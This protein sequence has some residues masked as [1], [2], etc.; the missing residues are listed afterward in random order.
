ML[1]FRKINQMTKGAPKSDVMAFIGRVDSDPGNCAIKSKARS[2]I[3][4]SKMTMGVKNKWLE[5][6]NS[7]LPICGTAKPMKAIGPQNAVM[8]P[9]NKLVLIMISVLALFRFSPDDSA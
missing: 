2:K 1:D 5:V 9:A 7:I 6:L 3:A 8:V 4:P